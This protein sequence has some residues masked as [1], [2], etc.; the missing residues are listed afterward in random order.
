MIELQ[1]DLELTTVEAARLLGAWLEGPVVC[2]EIIRLKGGMVNSVFR[3]EFDRPPHRAVVKIHGPG[4]DSFAAE[5]RALEYLGAHTSCPVPGVHLHDSSARLIPHAFLLLEHIP[6][7]CL[8]GLALEPGERADID[9]Q[10]AGVLSDLHGHTGPSFGPVDGDDSAR[11]WADIFT[12]RLVEAR[13]HPGLA[14]RLAPEVL[15]GV[16][17]AIGRAPHALAD[18]GPP[19]LVHGDVWNGNLVVQF[20]KGRWW[21]AGLL[22][23]D[24][25]F[26]DAELELAYLEVFDV[27]RQHFLAAYTAE[28]PLRAGYEQRRLFYWLHTALIHVALFGD[29]FFCEFTDRT[30][31]SI[32]QLEL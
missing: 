15:A 24:L 30:V 8:D 19:T 32:L 23:P 18:A 5:A 6:G 12:Q 2:S 31:R 22:D 26:A 25:Q 3:L 17:Q 10:L 1:P 7:E 27:P 9:A 20:E 28:R 29:E 14:E 21:L 11:G 16:D 4:S 13:A